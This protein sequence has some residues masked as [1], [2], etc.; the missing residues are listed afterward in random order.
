MSVSC[1]SV[2]TITLNTMRK[3]MVV[4]VGYMIPGPTAFRTALMSFVAWAMRSP[5]GV[6]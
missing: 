1:Q 3:I 6:L 5:V 2:Y 4:T